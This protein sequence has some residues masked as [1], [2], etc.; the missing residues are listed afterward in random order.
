MDELCGWHNNSCLIFSELSWDDQLKI[1]FCEISG[2]YSFEICKTAVWDSM[3]RYRVS[4]IWYLGLI[5]IT[6]W[7]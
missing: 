6:T 7:D 3:S 4:K 2:S 5:L 1:T